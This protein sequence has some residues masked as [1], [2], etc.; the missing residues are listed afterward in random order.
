[1]S[2]DNPTQRLEA[3][4]T[5]TAEVDAANPTPE[6]VAAQ[7]A[8]E[9]AVE[10]VNAAARSW[11]MIPYSIGG[12]LA[13]LAPE[14]RQVY[15]EEA[16]YEWGKAAAA[17]STKYGWDGPDDM[18]ELALITASMGFAVPSFFIVRDKMRELR[19]GKATG[20]LAKIGVW[21]RDRKAK[22]AAAE[23]ADAPAGG[24]PAEATAKG[25]A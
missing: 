10:Q 17:V 18:P 15:T 19:E 11:G 7:E 16:C 4:G 6:A 8:E 9:K 2:G 23:K 13:I 22:K 3:L 21:W 20:L 12:T 25:G 1:V 14:L 24:V 5:L